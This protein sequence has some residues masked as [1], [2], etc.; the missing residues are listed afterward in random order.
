MLNYNE[1][2]FRSK[3]STALQKVKTVLEV[4]RE[5]QLPAEIQH[6]YD[7]KY[8]LAEYLTHAAISSQ[9][10]TMKLLGLDQQKLKKIKEWSKQ[11]TVTLRF[12]A[13]ERC[14][15]NR[16]HT[17]K[18]DSGTEYVS[19]ATGFLG[20][21]KKIVSKTVTTVT[22]YYWD[23]EMNYELFFYCGTNI[24]D[25]VILQGRI[26][27]YEIK[28][29][30]WFLQQIHED[31]HCEFKIDRSLETCRTPRRNIDVEK[32]RAAFSSYTNWANQIDHYFI[33]NI[34]R[35]Q[36]QP[37]FDS[38]GLSTA[39]SQTFSPILPL[40]DEKNEI[41]KEEKKDE[42]T[43]E[44]LVNVNSTN[45]K[46]FLEPI[47]SI[48]DINNFLSE[49]RRSFRENLINLGKQFPGYAEGKTIDYLNLPYLK[50]CYCSI[51]N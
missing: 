20:G 19:E 18:V 1:S 11:R 10:D 26:G 49:Q 43:N 48:Q 33:H 14:T 46:W 35:I 2:V 45:G 31:L 6:K 13:E 7:D 22:D 21:I 23:F 42:I 36:S 3:V 39:K 34:F 8:S 25:K 37:Y 29:S 12:K 38:N 15:F 5:P 40:F 32:A 30:I 47:L 41:K 28:T 24:N 4:H 17:H 27:K 16:E 44:S 9:Y 50:I 51:H